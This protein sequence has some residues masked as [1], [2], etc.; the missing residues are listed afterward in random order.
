MAT[1]AHTSKSKN[2]RHNYHTVISLCDDLF[3]GLLTKPCLTRSCLEF[4]KITTKGVDAK[5]I[6]EFS[7]IEQHL[8]CFNESL[9]VLGTDP[10]PWMGKSIQ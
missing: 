10:Q 4:K 1:S 2:K 6:H 8:V 9:R 3:A 5:M 7:M